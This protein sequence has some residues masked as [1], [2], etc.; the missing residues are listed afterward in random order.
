MVPIPPPSMCEWSLCAQSCLTVCDAMDCNPTGSSV[1]GILL[2]RILEWVV[3]SFSRGSSRPRD[4]TRV[5]C[6]SSV[7]GRFFTRW[8]I[9]K[10]SCEIPTKFTIVG[11]GAQAEDCKCWV[12]MVWVQ[13]LPLSLSSWGTLSN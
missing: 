13:N 8:A 1:H 4:Q 10:L 6:V 11:Q 9:L 12:W 5:S 3:I 7:T 2:A